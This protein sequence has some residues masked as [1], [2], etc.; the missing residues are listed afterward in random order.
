M[1]PSKKFQMLGFIAPEYSLAPRLLSSDATSRRAGNTNTSL[2]GTDARQGHNS[3]VSIIARYHGKHPI[4][5]A[6]R[7]TGLL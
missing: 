7:A 4:S 3:L 2:A 5:I 6:P 1:V